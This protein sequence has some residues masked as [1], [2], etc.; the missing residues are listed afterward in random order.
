MELLDI[1]V[2]D[3][4]K[5]DD[6][7]MRWAR[8]S[9]GIEIRILSVEDMVG[10]LRRVCASGARIRTLTIIGHGDKVAI[11][12]GRDAVGLKT[13]PDYQGALALLEPLLVPGGTV[14]LAGCEVGAAKMLLIR[15]AALWPRVTVVAPRSLQV[16]PGGIAGSRTSCQS[17]GRGTVCVTTPAGAYDKFVAV[18]DAMGEFYERLSRRIFSW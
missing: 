15:L 17:I 16:L 4:S 9:K 14:I 1:T 10:K 3:N 18:A 7:G 2:I 11:W 5:P 13:L 8:T 6:P 12:I